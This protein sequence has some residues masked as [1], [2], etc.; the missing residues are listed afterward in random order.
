V[1]VVDKAEKETVFNDLWQLDL[2]TNQVHFCGT[3]APIGGMFGQTRQC[4]DDPLQLDPESYQAN[5]GVMQ[6][7]IGHILCVAGGAA[8]V[9][10]FGQI[11]CCC[12][13][14]RAQHG[15]GLRAAQQQAAC[16]CLSLEK[17]ANRTD[18]RA[19]FLFCSGSG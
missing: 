9:R 6:L 15:K 14:K 11:L 19:I 18:A 10:L 8:H 16:C 2:K 12:G 1:E 13:L 4:F 3:T 5:S 17:G 7:G